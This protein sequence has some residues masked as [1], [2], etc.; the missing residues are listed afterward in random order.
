MKGSARQL[1]IA[2][3]LASAVV[4][5][6]AT[7]PLL[8]PRIVEARPFAPRGNRASHIYELHR[9]A[10]RDSIAALAIAQLG[11]PYVLGGTTPQ[12]GFDCSGLVRYVFAHAFWTPPRTAQLQALSGI[13]IDRASLRPGDLL[14]FGDGAG[15]SH[16]GI[17]VGEGLYVH[18]SSIAGRVILSRV[19]RVPA[20]LIR[21]IRGARR[22]L[23]LGIDDAS[24][25]LAP[26]VD[27]YASLGKVERAERVDQGQRPATRVASHDPG[28]ALHRRAQLRPDHSPSG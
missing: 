24:Q 5:L 23:S 11:T 9:L 22:L 14:T 12:S 28:R 10:L 2:T 1:L 7:R 6:G 25:Q 20:K 19:D 21:P 8:S 15:V 16:V 26:S 4:S 17:Y 3:M 13:A 27:A 18:A